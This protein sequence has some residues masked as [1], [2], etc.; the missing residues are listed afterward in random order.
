MKF[1]PNFT[2]TRIEEN[3]YGTFVLPRKGKEYQS[4][5]SVHLL[6]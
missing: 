3:F 4:N 2:K 1:T 5:L 6:G